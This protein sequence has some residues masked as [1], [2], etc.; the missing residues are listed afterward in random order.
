M[1]GRSG[2]AVCGLYR[3]QGDEVSW[4]SLKTRVDR[5]PSL[6]LKNSSSGLVI[7]TSNHHDNFLVWPSK[8]SG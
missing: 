2:D 6:G 1:I 7:W 3:A 5:F 4:L 8:S